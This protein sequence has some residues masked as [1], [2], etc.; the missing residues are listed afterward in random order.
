MDIKRGNAL[1]ERLKP[2]AQTT[3]RAGVMGGVAGFRALFRLAGLGY[4]DPVLV[5]SVNMIAALR[6]LGIVGTIGIVAMGCSHTSNDVDARIAQVFTRGGAHTGSVTGEQIPLSEA[7]ARFYQQRRYQSAWTGNDGL[8]WRGRKVVAVLE[9]SSDE[10]LDPDRYAYSTIR[11]LEEMA[12]GDYREVERGDVPRDLDLL[13]TSGFLLYATDLAKGALDPGAVGLGWHIDRGAAPG[14]ALLDS[15]AA[16]ANAREL[17][18]ALLPTAPQYAALKE[19]LTRYREIARNGGWPLIDHTDLDVGQSHVD[20]ATLR[21]RLLAEGDPREVELAGS[22]AESIDTIDT[23]LAEALRHFQNRHGLEETGTVDLPTRAALN[24]TVEER[25]AQLRLN[26]DRWRMLPAQLGPSYILVNVA[27]FELDVVEA[28]RSILQMRVVVGQ[29]ANQ[30]PVFADTMQYMVVNPYWNV[31]ESIRN[32][33][34][35]PALQKDP[36]YMDRHSMEIARGSDVTVVDHRS[37][38]WGDV[39]AANFP[40]AVRQR[41]GRSNALGHVKFVLPNNMNIYLHD[42]PADQLFA[43][44]RRA[45]SHGCIRL[46]K[47]LELARLILQRS[48]ERS[49][50][51]LDELLATGKEKTIKLDWQ[52]PVYILYFTAW[53]EDHGGV[54]FHPDVYGHDERLRPQVET[55]LAPANPSALDRKIGKQQGREGGS[56]ALRHSRSTSSLS[57]LAWNFSRAGRS[58]RSGFQRARVH[59]PFPSL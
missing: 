56:R 16:G 49:L 13:V 19:A 52:I 39:D 18:R 31:P 34:I 2:L 55:R 43:R 44:T 58:D 53:V 24:V 4:R 54:R 51:D 40:Y 22:S 38:D 17:T 57:D 28:D 9:A 3:V 47:P 48:T 6:V 15:V 29:E 30:T 11:R 7:T 42:S 21:A 37:I 59:E 23:G 25:I 41:P 33:E 1:V 35:I 32:K 26:L 46:E 5:S 27:G 8:N 36:G 50:D 20:L 12:S 45:F 14:V 10:G